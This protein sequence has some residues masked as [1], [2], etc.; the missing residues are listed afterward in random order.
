MN[1]HP[2][3]AGL[4]IAQGNSFNVY[5]IRSAVCLKA[6]CFCG[7]HAI[8]FSFGLSSIIPSQPTG[9]GARAS[10]VVEDY[11]RSLDA[12]IYGRCLLP[13]RERVVVALPKGHSAAR[14]KDV[15]LGAL[16]GELLIMPSKDLF[17]GLHQM[18]ASAFLKNQVRLGRYQTVEHFQTAVNLTESR[19]GYVFL[20][21]SAKDFVPDGVVLRTPGFSIGPVDT[22]ALWSRGNIDPLVHRV[23][24]LLKEIKKKL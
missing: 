14:R 6:S 4:R 13:T 8:V 23:L 2:K 18:I 11:F 1:L 15:G 22:F 7:F 21:A 9:F 5:A 3:F 17:P 12:A 20:P 10:A 24:S 19:A 16:E